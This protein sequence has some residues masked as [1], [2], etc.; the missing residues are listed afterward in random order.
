MEQQHKKHVRPVRCVCE[1]WPAGEHRISTE[2]E[3]VPGSVPAR[4]D[5]LEWLWSAPRESVEPLYRWPTASLEASVASKA[6]AWHRCDCGSGRW[7]WPVCSRGAVLCQKSPSVN[8]W[9]AYGCYQNVHKTWL[10]QNKAR[11]S[12]PSQLDPLAIDDLHFIHSARH[13][14]TLPHH[15]C[16]L[17]HHALCLFTPQLSL[18]LTA[19]THAGMARL[20]W[21]GWLVIHQDCLPPCRD[22]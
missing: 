4:W 8:H 12:F 17:V 14:L 19:P 13:Q 18:V 15:G 11:K 6:A 22:G 20:S 10:A 9:C 7:L 3:V 1:E 2:P 5:T 21:P 16:R